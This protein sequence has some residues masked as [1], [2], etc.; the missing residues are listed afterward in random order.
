MTANELQFQSNQEQARANAAREA[1]NLRSN[2]AKEEETRRSNLVREEE[3]KRSNLAREANEQRRTDLTED[4][5]AYKHIMGG[6]E[7]G[8]DTTLGVGKLVF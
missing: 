2:R 1:E 7:F 4:D 6:L 8:R 3:T 5:L